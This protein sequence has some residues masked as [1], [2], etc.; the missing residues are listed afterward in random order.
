MQ[1]SWITWFENKPF[2]STSQ[3]WPYILTPFKEI[4]IFRRTIE[5]SFII[6]FR[7]GWQ[8]I[9]RDL[10]TFTK[11]KHGISERMLL[12][13]YLWMFNRIGDIR[14]RSVEDGSEDGQELRRKSVRVDL[15]TSGGGRGN[16][17]LKS[18][19]L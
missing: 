15:E 4:V 2:T 5:N 17:Q 18:I 12:K 11:G 3:K 1:S 13:K 8:R 7:T 19:L 9:K 10:F 14:R 16:K 6:D